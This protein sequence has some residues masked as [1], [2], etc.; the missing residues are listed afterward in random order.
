[1]SVLQSSSRSL[2]RRDAVCVCVSGVQSLPWVEDSSLCAVGEQLRSHLE[3]CCVVLCSVLC[4]VLC[5]VLCCAVL[6]C[7]VLCC[8]V[9]CA[10]L[11]VV[12][13]AVLCVVCC[14]VLCVVC[15]RVCVLLVHL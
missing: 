1:M 13:C 5:A 11:C 12:C 15:V 3:L 7:V 9:C 2:Y 4:S 6:C 14:A 10:V 8:V